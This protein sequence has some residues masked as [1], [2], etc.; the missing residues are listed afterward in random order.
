M[1]I[2]NRFLTAHGE[3]VETILWDTG[4]CYRR[5]IDMPPGTVLMT[6]LAGQES[7]RAMSVPLVTSVATFETQLTQNLFSLYRGSNG[8]F[9][10]YSIADHETFSQ[11]TSWLEEIRKHV[12]E[13]VPIMLIGNQ[14]DRST[15]RAVQTSHAQAFA[16]EFSRISN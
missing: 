6:L 11:C 7:F 12:D 5:R 4:E 15:E 8:V 3:L 1:D 16:R 10:V 13:H 9:L 2:A 14:V